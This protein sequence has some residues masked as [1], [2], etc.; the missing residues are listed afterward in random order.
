MLEIHHEIKIKG[1][2]KQIRHALVDPEALAAWHGGHVSG[3][4][5]SR[6]FRFEDGPS[7]EWTVSRPDPEH[8]IWS[9]VDGPGDAA[10]TTARFSTSP[11]DKGRT[12]LE[13]VHSGWPHAGGNFRKCNT[14]WAILLHHLR[15]YIET[16]QADPA[17][18]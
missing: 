12:L 4:G 10:G 2:P 3:S 18:H 11:A 17:L 14:R 16:G 13:F 6:R 5:D 15:R 1:D 9:C 8:V 7:F